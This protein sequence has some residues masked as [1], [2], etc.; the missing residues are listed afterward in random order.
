MQQSFKTQIVQSA[1]TDCAQQTPSESAI[2]D[3]GLIIR[4]SESTAS[5]IIPLL[6]L[7]PPILCTMVVFA[8]SFIINAAWLHLLL[9]VTP[10][11]SP[12]P[13]YSMD[14][15]AF[16][17]SLNHS[18]HDLWSSH[19]YGIALLILSLSIILPMIKL[20]YLLLLTL[21]LSFRD[22]SCC[23]RALPKWLVADPKESNVHYAMLIT[24]EMVNKLS[25]INIFIL[26]ILMS[27]LY[28]H[29]DDSLS[30]DGSK[31]DQFHIASTVLIQ[32]DLGIVLFGIA[33]TAS[34]VLSIAVKYKY[35][36][37][38][39]SPAAHALSFP[40]APVLNERPPPI[41]PHD[42]DPHRTAASMPSLTSFSGFNRRS[43]GVDAETQSPLLFSKNYSFRSFCVKM[44]SFGCLVVVVMGAI[45]VYIAQ[46]AVIEVEYTGQL[47]PH[48]D[49]PGALRVYS[50]DGIVE[51]VDMERRNDGY[52][53]FLRILYELFGIILPLITILLLIL[54]WMIPMPKWIHLRLKGV[55]WCCHLLNALDVIL[56]CIVI[57]A[58]EL[59]STFR[60]VVDHQYADY[61]RK[62]EEE[63]HDEGLCQSMNIRVAMR[64][65][66]W[67]GLAF[68]VS[69][70][71][72]VV[73]S[74]FFSE[75]SYS[76]RQRRKLKIKMKNMEREELGG[77]TFQKI[78]ENKTL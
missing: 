71:I 27:A 74:V 31:Y 12:Y 8:W 60:Y 14:Q 40:F 69:T 44:L 41:S 22:K 21:I 63:V 50:L 19:S 30:V 33:M 15:S 56:I 3:H 11:H 26:V 32:P 73:Y 42:S 9:E 78:D 55:I 76:P 59:P 17:L 38:T 45:T 77:T 43:S 46:I 48:M 13:M 24:L 53:K 68:Y 58:Q 4:K 25:L 1:L 47:A 49:H 37:S 23:Q 6:L 57:V 52:T 16:D 18:L 62:L 66:I 10:P 39:T 70:W 51:S 2:G 54:L 72:V 64:D 7:I 28:V 67:V 5:R 61:C 34:S 75:D 20:L 29:L 36:P 65:G 35:I